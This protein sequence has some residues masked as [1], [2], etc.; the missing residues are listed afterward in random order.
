[1]LNSSGIADGS[2]DGCQARWSTT[3]CQNLDRDQQA[4]WHHT[5]VDED[6]APSQK[7]PKSSTVYGKNHFLAATAATT[8]I[9]PTTI[10]LAKRP[11]PELLELETSLATSTTDD[12]TVN[13]GMIRL[14]CFKLEPGAIG[15]TI[16][17]RSGTSVMG[18]RPFQLEILPNWVSGV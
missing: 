5:L 14:I 18:A 9:I 17:M 4:G 1:M 7:P 11:L 2:G 3:M 15:Y 12:P 10:N 16:K 13:A 6:A 8:A